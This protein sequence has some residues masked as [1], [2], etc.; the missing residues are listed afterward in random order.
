MSGGSKFPGM[1]NDRLKKVMSKEAT[2]GTVLKYKVFAN[3]AQ[4]LRVCK[5]TCF[6][7]NL[8]I[9]QLT[10]CKEVI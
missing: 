4:K 6:I 9:L 8:Q 2:F 3:R 1:K 10:C 7:P 5:S